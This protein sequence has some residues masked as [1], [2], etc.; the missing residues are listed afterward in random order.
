MKGKRSTVATTIVIQKLEPVRVVFCSKLTFFKSTDNFFAWFFRNTVNIKD[1]INIS[2]YHARLKNSE[3][4]IA[5]PVK[6]IRSVH[7]K[8]SSS[9][10]LLSIMRVKLIINRR[11]FFDC[12]ARGDDFHP[13]MCPMNITKQCSTNCN[14]IT[15]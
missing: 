9:S 3:N 13:K 14:K 15:L 11:K 7:V 5:F 8:A 2:K 1:S 12:I 10:T 6:N 4:E